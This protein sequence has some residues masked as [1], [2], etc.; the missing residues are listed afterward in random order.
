MSASR[1][2]RPPPRALA[3]DRPAR[4]SLASRRVL[5]GDDLTLVFENRDTLRFRLQELARVARL[6]SAAHVR[7]ELDWYG[8]LLPESGRLRAALWLGAAGRRPAVSERH[9]VA[10]SLVAFEDATG[11]AVAGHFRADRVRDRLIGLAGRV[12]FAF[13]PHDVEAFATPGRG[14][15]LAVVTGGVRQTSAV[16]DDGV[17]RSLNADVT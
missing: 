14:W 5:V 3:A 2:H 1:L 10:G 17:W 6:T 8:R 9:T 12:E 7:H 13:T 15:R 16:L 4:D 11:H